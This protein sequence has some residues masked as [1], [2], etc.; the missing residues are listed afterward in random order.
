MVTLDASASLAQA[1]L[2]ESSRRKPER[3]G[4]LGVREELTGELDDAVHVVL[5]DERAP[6][7]QPGQFGVGQFARRHDEAGCAALGP[8]VMVPEARSIA[9][10]R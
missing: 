10:S 3:A 6:H 1:L 9:E 7:L 2:E 4:N 8:S 5:L